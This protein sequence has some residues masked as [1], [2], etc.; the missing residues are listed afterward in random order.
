MDEGSEKR[1]GREERGEGRSR[2]VYMNNN[3]N[4]NKKPFLIREAN[5]PN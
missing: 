5:L 3:N 1:S 2:D 4:K